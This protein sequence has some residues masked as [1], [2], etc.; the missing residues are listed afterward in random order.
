M[1]N[2]WLATSDTDR[3]L[4]RKIA[5]DPAQ[6]TKQAL[7]PADIERLVEN[8]TPPRSGGEGASTSA[9]TSSTATAAQIGAGGSASSGGGNSHS[10]SQQ[11]TADGGDM[12][13]TRDTA[14]KMMVHRLNTDQRGW[15]GML[16]RQLE[17]GMQNGTQALRIILEPGNLGKLNVDLYFR[18]GGAAI[19]MAAETDEAARLLSV[20]RHY[21]SQML[22]GAGMRLASLQTVTSSTSDT[23]ADGQNG[24]HNHAQQDS[25]G[26]NSSGNQSFANKMR[27]ASQDKDAQD[28]ALD[29][30][31]GGTAQ[32]QG[33]ET[34]VISILA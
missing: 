4:A 33:H 21:L 17:T 13:A 8:V 15:G 16:V 29:D 3:A 2:E 9:S 34:A 31:P 10:G 22:E 27:D 20:S 7:T 11:G 5:F 26:K 25:S 32:P 14:S 28:V 12:P 19:R 18:D 30:V 6:T 1:K 24:N 23:G